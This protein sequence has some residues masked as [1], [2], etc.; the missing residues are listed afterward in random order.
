MEKGCMNHFRHREAFSG[1]SPDHWA[2]MKQSKKK[3]KLWHI[4]NWRSEMKLIVDKVIDI[5]SQIFEYRQK[6]QVYH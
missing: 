2:C 4:G 3:W 1:A 5:Q 6:K